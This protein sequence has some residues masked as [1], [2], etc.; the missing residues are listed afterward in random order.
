MGLARDE[1]RRL[2]R[3]RGLRATAPRLAVL[4]VL[5]EADQPLAFSEVTAR[6]EGTDCDPATVYRNLVKLREAGLA[7]VV[8]QAGGL[9]RYAL[10][11]GDEHRHPHFLCDDCGVVT[12]LPE[13]VSATLEADGPWSEAVAEAMVQLRGEC[14]DC[15]SDKPSPSTRHE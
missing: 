10:S 14:P 7:P 2:L 6:L 5:A 4:D 3:D 9:D 13:A 15:R 1:A 12:C 8:S 11:T